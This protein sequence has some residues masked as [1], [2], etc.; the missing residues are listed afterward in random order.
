MNAHECKPPRLLPTSL[1]FSVSI[2][3]TPSSHAPNLTP[4]RN[5]G[6]Y[7]RVRQVPGIRHLENLS[8]RTLDNSRISPEHYR[9]A[10]QLAQ[11]AT[12]VG[13]A[14]AALEERDK[15]GGEG[16]GVPEPFEDAIL[17]EGGGGRRWW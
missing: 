9:I 16:G 15:V 5:C 14:E 7:L 10:I 13:E 2:L 4:P 1:H 17:G 11:A 12:G 6:A 3:A 8:F